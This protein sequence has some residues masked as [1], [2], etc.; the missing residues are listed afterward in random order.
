MDNTLI[1][2]AILIAAFF[3]LVGLGVGRSTMS[4]D[5]RDQWLRGYGDGF[6]HALIALEASEHMDEADRPAD[7]HFSRA[8]MKVSGSYGGPGIVRGGALTAR[9]EPRLV[10]GHQIGGGFGEM[11]HIYRH[12]DIAPA[13]PQSKERAAA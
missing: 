12:Q 4:D 6:R 7:L 11:L 1:G 2:G 13:D 3:F 8:V 5:E 9:G 10:V